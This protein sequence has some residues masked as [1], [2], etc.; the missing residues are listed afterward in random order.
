VVEPPA[1]VRSTFCARLSAAARE[2]MAFAT[3]SSGH[4]EP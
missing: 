2:W 4:S 3:G 1:P